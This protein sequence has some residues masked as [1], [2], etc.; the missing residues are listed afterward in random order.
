MTAV[1]PTLARASVEAELDAAR[2]WAI[3][4]RWILWWDPDGLRL[5]AS[6]YHPKAKRLIEVIAE[7]DGYPAVPPAWRFV[8]PATDNTAQAAFPAAGPNSIF[9]TNPV[10]CAPWNRLAYSENGGPHGDWSGPSSWLKVTGLTV[11][12]TVPDMLAT[13]NLHLHQ[14]PGMMA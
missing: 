9:H 3:R 12:H 6:T 5:R 10:I 14:S 7:L 1:P 8:H 13:L 11:A 4:H 2:A